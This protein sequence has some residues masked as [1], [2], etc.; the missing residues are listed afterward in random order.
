LRGNGLPGVTMHNHAAPG[1]GPVP[2]TAPEPVF[3]DNII[4]GNDISENAQDSGD[5]AT[6]GP[7]GINIYS[8]GP[9]TGTIISQNVIRQEDFDIVIKIPAAA[10]SAVQI[11]LNNITDSSAVGL[12][13]AGAA[14]VDATQNWWGCSG[15]PN[16]NG[17][18]T[19]SGS[20]V[21]FAPWLTMPFQAGRDH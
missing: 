4:L 19:L 10:V 5:A 6:T 1:V 8:V 20:G 2:P 17:C 16:A 11:H 13:N 9:M 18:A 12:L 15:G 3:N 7:T 21:L 14:Q